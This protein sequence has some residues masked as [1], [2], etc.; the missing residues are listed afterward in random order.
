MGATPHMVGCGLPGSGI[1][2]SNQTILFQLFC[3]VVWFY[4]NCHAAPFLVCMSPVNSQ[5]AGTSVTL[6]VS[7]FI[8]EQV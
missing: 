2:L 1:Q 8:T 6:F 4:L 3:R 7:G 5:G